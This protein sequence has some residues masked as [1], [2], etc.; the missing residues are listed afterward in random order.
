[1][2]AH[3]DA[4]VLSQ[5]PQYS[6]N[7]NRRPAEEKESCDGSNVKDGDPDAEDPVELAGGLLHE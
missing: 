2:V 3:G 5:D 1:M 6:G 7:D 4:H